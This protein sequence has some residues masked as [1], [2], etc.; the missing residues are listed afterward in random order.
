MA[1]APTAT[2]A[3]AGQTIQRRL[4]ATSAAGSAEAAAALA[5]GAVFEVTD[6]DPFMRKFPLSDVLPRPVYFVVAA[7]LAPASDRGALP[8][9][10]RALGP[11]GLVASRDQLEWR[12]YR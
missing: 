10:D 2:T 1:M 7:P 8:A 11:A 12:A 3:A 5:L 4:C 6:P 9:L